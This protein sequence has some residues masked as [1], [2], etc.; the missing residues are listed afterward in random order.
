MRYFY[1][2]L[3]LL[4]CTLSVHAQRLD[5][6]MMSEEDVAHETSK[7]DSIASSYFLTG[8]YEEALIYLLRETNYLESTP[9]DPRYIE[10]LVK[11]GLCYEQLNIP[12]KAIEANKRA[13]TLHS[14]NLSAEDAFVANR[15]NYVANLYLKMDDKEEAISWAR[16]ALRI[17]GKIRISANDKLKHMKTASKIYFVMNKYPEAIKYQKE[18]ID[19][20]S[21]YYDP[22]YEEY[23]EQLTI[24]RNYY[25][26]AGDTENHTEVS[27][28]IRQLNKELEE[29]IIPSPT[30]LSTP[31]LCR[32]HN[33]EALL[34]SRWILGNYLSTKGMKEAADYLSRFRK[35]TPDVAVYLGPDELSW[36]KRNAGFYLAYIAASVEYALTHMD[37][38]RYSL[39]QY[40]AAMYRLLDYYKENKNF[41]G[42]IKRLDKYLSMQKSKP[43]ELEKRLEQNFEDFLNVMES[44]KKNSIVVEDPI[45]MNFSY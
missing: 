3:F 25:S 13:I 34:C 33:T 15:S 39:A 10:A 23:L 38:Q 28:Q 44:R 7:L 36:V 9:N 4:C 29:G 20:L 14:A 11:M 8:D 32:R 22:H 27:D 21:Q 1:C 24:L 12:F 35:N 5:R 18:V 30:N 2:C 37:D 41:A 40:K 43:E 42:E 16:E 19:L 6:S 26:G 31:A 45:L 17:D